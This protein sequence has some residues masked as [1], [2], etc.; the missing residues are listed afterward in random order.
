[1]SNR[2]NQTTNPTIGDV[3]KERF[4]RRKLLGGL[5]KTI[6]AAALMS[7]QAEAVE[8]NTVPAALADGEKKEVSRSSRINFTAISPSRAD[9][10]SVAEGYKVGV[11]VKWGDPLTS[12]APVHD[13][14]NQT[15]TAQSKQFGYN[16]DWLDFFPLPS[17]DVPNPGHGLLVVNNEYTNPELMFKNWSA[18]SQTKE[19]TDVELNAHGL[20]VVEV[21]RDTNGEWYYIQAGAQN[22]RITAFT[23]MTLT[24]PA[25]G[26]DLLKTSADPTGR[27][28]SGTLNNCSGGRTPWGTVLSG[29]ENFNQ[30]FSNVGQLPDGRVKTIHSRYGVTSGASAYPWLRHYDRFDV[31]KEPNEPLRFGWVVEFDPYDPTSVPKKRTALGR[32]KHEAAT[33][34]VASNGKVV[35]YTGDDERFQFAYKF[36]SNRTYNHFDRKANDGLLDDGTLYV[37]KFNADGSGEWLPLVAGQGQLTSANGYGTQAEVLI[38]TR[39]AAAAVGATPMDRPEDMEVNP[40]NGKIYLALT[41]NTQR[42]DTNKD[43][44]NPRANNRYGHILEITEDNGDHTATKFFWEIFILC[45]DGTNEAHGTFFAGYDPT[46]VSKLANPD[47]ITFDSKGNLWI[48][49]DGQPGVLNINDGVFAVP[50]DGDE[51]GRVR[52]LFSSVVGAEVSSLVFNPDDTTMFI[53]IQHPGEGGKWTDNASDLTSTFPDGRAPNRPAVLTVSRASGNPVVGS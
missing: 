3:M 31:V 12:D 18:A 5:F 1:M 23:P 38:D 6:P 44:S 53:S 52:Q 46:K 4:D 36:V 48:A 17:H 34:Q 41:N 24:G 13:P 50:T 7:S 45:G 2:E 19:Q 27:S 26:H 40:V 11:L 15:A 33:I 9:T 28:V 14:L 37:A 39:G 29:E 47:N 20:S 35:A 49:T 42:T 32:L 21:K 16:C 30:Y 25:A 51:R 8:T 43:A 10:I 22:R